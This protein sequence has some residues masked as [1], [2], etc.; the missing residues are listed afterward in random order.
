MTWT[1]D[2]ENRLDTKQAYLVIEL[3]IIDVRSFS[4]KRELTLIILLTPIILGGT[5]QPVWGTLSSH[6]GAASA[7]PTGI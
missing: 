2:I 5:K 3:Q 4:P 7:E 1:G 6:Q